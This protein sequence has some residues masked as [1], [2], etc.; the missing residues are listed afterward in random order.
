VAAKFGFVRQ[1]APKI[2]ALAPDYQI[3][4]IHWA[5]GATALAGVI[6][7][8]IVFALAWLLGRML[9]PGRSRKEI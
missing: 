9:V 4:G 5:T 6:G 1:A 8:L 2:A 3:P 7:A